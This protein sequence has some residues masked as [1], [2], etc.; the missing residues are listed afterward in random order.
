MF[1]E[2]LQQLALTEVSA[3]LQHPTGTE[4]T[5]RE[6]ILL[7]VKEW[8]HQIAPHG[9]TFDLCKDALLKAL[10]LDP[11]KEFWYSMYKL[12]DS[13]YFSE[14]ELG[15]IEENP[16][17]GFRNNYCSYFMEKVE[18]TITRVREKPE[19]MRSML[20]KAT[21]RKCKSQSIPPYST[22]F[23]VTKSPVVSSS[24]P[25]TLPCLS[26]PAGAH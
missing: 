18:P 16:L 3:E 24:L 7:F 5:V 19:I 6:R 25:R 14:T 21:I 11:D 17:Q 10:T 23:I 20:K 8:P 1:S 12:L 9:V 13:F 4:T 15:I 2:F 26:M 22:S